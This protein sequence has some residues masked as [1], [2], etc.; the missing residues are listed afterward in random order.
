MNWDSDVRPVRT[1]H[2]TDMRLSK[3]HPNSRLS[4][5]WYTSDHSVTVSRTN[6]Q[7]WSLPHRISPGDRY[8]GGSGSVTISADMNISTPIFVGGAGGD[9]TSRPP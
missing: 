9:S 7:P 2:T 4:L 8:G 1:V 3:L 6:A 5:H